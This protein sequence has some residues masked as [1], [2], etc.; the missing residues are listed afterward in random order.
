[1]LSSLDIYLQLL[2]KTSNLYKCIGLDIYKKN[3]KMNWLIIGVVLDIIVYIIANAYSA[4]I[5][6]ND[7]E[8]FMFCLITFALGFMVCTYRMIYK[9]YFFLINKNFH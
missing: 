1:M 7:F 2:T 6:R 8:K 9:L 3:Y 4:Y 5:Y